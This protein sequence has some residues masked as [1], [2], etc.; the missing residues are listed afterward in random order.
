MQQQGSYYKGLQEAQDTFPVRWDWTLGSRP[1]GKRNGGQGINASLLPHEN[2]NAA[3]PA[4]SIYVDGAKSSA[5]IDTGCSRT[6][7]DA[8][9]CQSWRRAIVNVM[10]IGDM[11][12]LCCGDGMVTA[13]TE[14]GSS[15]KISVLVLCGKPLRFDL[16]LRITLEKHW[17]AW[18][19]DQQDRYNSDKEIVKCAA[20]SINEPDFTATFNHRSQAWTV[21]WNWSEEPTPEAEDNR[22]AEY[23]VAAEI[24]L[25]HERKLRTWMSSGWLVPN[26][27]EELG[28]LKGLIPQ[29]AVLQQHKSKVRPVMDFLQLKCQVDVFIANADVYKAKLR[30][31]R[32][33][34]SNVSLLDLNRAYRQVRVQKSLWPFQ[35]I[36][37]YYLIRLGLGLNVAPL[38]MKAI[39]SAVLSQEEAVGHAA[40][41]YIDDI[42]FNEDVMSATCVREHLARFGLEFKDPERLEDGAWALGSAVAMKHGKLRWK[43]GSMVPGSL[44]IVTL[45]AV[46]SLCGRFV[47]HFP[48]CG[49]LCVACRVLKRRA[50][51]VTKSWDDETRDNLLQRMIS[52]TVDFVRWD[53]PAHGDWCV[54]RR[55]LN[56]WVDDSSLAIGVALERHETVLED[57]CWLRPEND[58]QHINLAELD[59]VLKGINLALQWQC[60][61]LRVKT[62]SVCVHHWVSDTLTRRT[63]VHTKAATEM[64]IRRQLNTLKKL[65]KEYE[66]TVDVVLSKLHVKCSTKLHVT[67][68]TLASSVECSPMAREIWVQSK[69]ESYQRLKKWYL[70]L[71]CLTLSI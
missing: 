28:P 69:V 56:V 62:D 33:K 36:K 67:F 9:R 68:P 5:L 30:E 43:R 25:D 47:R 27:E 48:V 51:S 17:E 8:D 24:R 7:I 42:Y 16:L 21:A 10:M 32:Q 20:I 58:A 41:A 49:W 38:I 29:M 40:F 71:P 11:S 63:W 4:A 6:I 64:L 57:A 12:R 3:L 46:F 44:D 52:E 15:A 39:V 65:M 50:S 22:V 53:D 66:L 70:M 26:K 2:V 55:E 18:L 35:T 61:L 13:S 59:A 1:F 60:K 34:G 37:R 23:A 54:D 19:L 31:C 45:R 14:E